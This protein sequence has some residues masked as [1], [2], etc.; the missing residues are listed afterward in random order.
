M[1]NK[2]SVSQ[3]TFGAF[4][5][6]ALIC[7]IVGVTTVVNGLTAASASKYNSDLLELRRE[8]TQFKNALTEHAI[9]GDS[10]MLSSDDVYKAE[11]IEEAAVLSQRFDELAESFA[12]TVPEHAQDVRDAKTLWLGY[13]EGWML[14]QFAMMER[15]DSI[16]YARQ[17]ESS[18]EGRDRFHEA[19]IALDYVESEVSQHSA[20]ATQN[21]A[22]ASRWILIIAIAGAIITLGASI[23]L[24][25]LFNMAVSNPLRRI[26]DVTRDL[27]DGKANVRI[28]TY[29][30]Q[31]EVGDISRALTVFQENLD[32]TAELEAEQ[33]NAKAEAE[34]E[35]KETMQNIA[36][37]F[38][39]TVM[40]S[41][42]EMTLSIGALKES[43]SGVMRSAETTGDRATE[44]SRS[45]AHTAS[46]V[47]AVAGAAEEMA[48]TISDISKRVG[49]V[50]TMAKEGEV[51]GQAV[52]NE[53]KALGQVVSD[54]E[55]IVRLIADIAEQT[56]LLALNATIEAAR[57]G[58]M[59]KGFAVVASE[60]KELASQTANATNDV[61]RQ[62]EAVRK[63]AGDVDAAS[64]VVAKMIDQLNSV[65]G[66]LAAAMDQQS[67]ATSEIASNVDSAAITAN[68]VTDKIGE[69]SSIANETGEAASKIGQEADHLIERA[70]YLREQ[71]ARFVEQL[72]AS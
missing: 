42:S 3:K 64:D 70:K 39:D 66:A 56:N 46:S 20:E 37:S 13:S 50:A 26:V 4:L 67:S 31:D 35:R 7:V 43:S 34:R 44:V 27:A 24:G 17:R 63:S 21:A 48:V 52:S 54:I 10:Y 36:R 65:S 69:V 51:A 25:I 30:S 29:T 38:E 11:F 2:L 61:A 57:A 72:M 18:G 23:G 12:T 16:D 58:E 45:T 5:V 9:V 62:I 53:V 14:E 15:L 59:G 71:S 47:T 32:R 49:E 28:P 1:L 8:V 40:S 68:A 22:S 33:A 19:S 41:I 60:V 55:S 6:L